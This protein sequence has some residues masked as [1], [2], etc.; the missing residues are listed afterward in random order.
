M[1]WTAAYHGS[2]IKKK[3]KN[4]NKTDKIKK[5]TLLHHGNIYLNVNIILYMFKNLMGK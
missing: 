3:K 1:C 4:Q 2:E 5:A